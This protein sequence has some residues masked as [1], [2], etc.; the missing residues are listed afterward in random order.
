MK[1]KVVKNF[2]ENLDWLTEQPIDY[3]I[4]IIQEH[5]SLCQVLINQLAEESISEF[6][7]EKGSH[8]KPYQGQYSRYGFNNSSVRIGDRKV[9][10]QAQRIKDNITDQTFKPDIYDKLNEN[11]ADRK[12]VV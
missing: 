10:I 4:S 7:G 12:S 5:L 11:S 2:S 9:A 3:R 6:V 8:Q 1:T